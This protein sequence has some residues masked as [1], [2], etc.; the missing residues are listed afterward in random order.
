L[1]L[2]PGW[3]SCANAPFR[4]HKTWVHEGGI[5]T[6]WIVHW[7]AGIAAKGELR[8]QPVHAIDLVP[9]VLDY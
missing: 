4:R 7:P 6:P 9:T 8:R 1:C 5:A 3:S 2:G